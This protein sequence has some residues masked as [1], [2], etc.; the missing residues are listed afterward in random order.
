LLDAAM[1]ASDNWCESRL[2]SATTSKSCR[3]LGGEARAGLPLVHMAVTLWQS[4]Q[5]ALAQ[6]SGGILKIPFIT[7]QTIQVNGG[8]QYY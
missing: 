8:A 5:G 1:L 2:I 4:G 6:K 7:G 3:Q